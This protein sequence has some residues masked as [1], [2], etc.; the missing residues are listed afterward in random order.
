VIDNRPCGACR[1]LVSAEKGC[2]HWHPNQTVKAA[3]NREHRQRQQAEVDRMR[4]ML[5]GDVK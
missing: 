3:R 4:R 1:A 2:Q 5:T